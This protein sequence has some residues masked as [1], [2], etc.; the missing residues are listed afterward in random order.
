MYANVLVQTPF[1]AS[2]YGFS[3]KEE[4]ATYKTGIYHKKR[5]SVS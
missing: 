1:L 5:N 4:G 3:S 2:K